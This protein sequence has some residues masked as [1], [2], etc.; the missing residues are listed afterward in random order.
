MENRK[1]GILSKKEKR[2]KYLK[3]FVVLL[4]LSAVPLF[5]SNPTQPLC[6]TGVNG[7]ISYYNPYPYSSLLCHSGIYGIGYDDNRMTDYISIE[8]GDGT[9]Y[10]FEND[11]PKLFN[12]VKEAIQNHLKGRST[13]TSYV[14]NNFGQISFEYAANADGLNIITAVISYLDTAINW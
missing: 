7:D 9:L 11:N 1:I 14:Y 4:L 10:L 8:C 3:W 12:E 5:G 6:L 13:K 2:M